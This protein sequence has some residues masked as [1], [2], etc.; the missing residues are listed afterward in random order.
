M[1]LLSTVHGISSSL[2]VAADAAAVSKAVGGSGVGVAGGSTRT[3]Q[4][5]ISY[6]CRSNCLVSVSEDSQEAVFHL[7]QHPEITNSLKGFSEGEHKLDSAPPSVCALDVFGNV[8]PHPAGNGCLQAG[9]HRLTLA[10][11]ISI[12]FNT[13]GP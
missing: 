10:T 5:Y 9:A 12:G 6:A 1:Q 4:L 2:A 13:R 11:C 3:V 8:W 7:L